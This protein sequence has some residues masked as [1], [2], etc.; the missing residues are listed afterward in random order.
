VK[1][2]RQVCQGLALDE[3]DRTIDLLPPA[4]PVGNPRLEISLLSHSLDMYPDLRDPRRC[5]KCAQLTGDLLV[6]APINGLGRCRFRLTAK[7]V[8]LSPRSAC[9]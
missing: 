7:P 9:Q 4:K 2:G 6:I 1:V 3:A 5:V 8:T